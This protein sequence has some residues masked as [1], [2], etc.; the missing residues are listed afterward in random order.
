MKTESRTSLPGTPSPAS[1]ETASTALSSMQRPEVLPPHRAP[2]R[3]P[4]FLQD[5]KTKGRVL[6][7][8]PAARS[9]NN[10]TIRC[11]FKKQRI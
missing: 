5:G 4:P 2:A 6:L 1:M 7:T 11:R 9:E 10:P 8:F 3:D